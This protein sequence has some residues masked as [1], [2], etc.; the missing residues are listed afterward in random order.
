MRGGVPQN[1]LLN[2]V[3][4]LLVVL[5]AETLL[6]SLTR[7]LLLSQPAVLRWLVTLLL[8]G[9]SAYAVQRTRWLRPVP[10]P[11][12]LK[13]GGVT[14][15]VL[16]TVQTLGDRVRELP[17]AAGLGLAALLSLLVAW[18]LWRIGPRLGSG[19]AWLAGLGALA[20][21]FTLYV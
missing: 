16:Y 18:L 15:L 7:P 19:R 13:F 10:R 17:Q 8:L 1:P 12:W 21:F 5:I 6:V 11:D 14:L 4:V 20:A 9:A 3:I 2:S